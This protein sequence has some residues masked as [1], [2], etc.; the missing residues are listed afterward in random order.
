[1]KS[2]RNN[3]EHAANLMAKGLGLS[4]KD[5][6]TAMNEIIL[7]DKSEQPFYFKD[8]GELQQILFATGNFLFEQNSISRKPEQDVINNA[9]NG[10]L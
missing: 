8:G 10:T 5:T 4:V 7:K 1:M 6:T 3:P 9:I 2:Y